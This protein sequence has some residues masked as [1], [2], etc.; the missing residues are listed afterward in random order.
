VL[1]D[2]KLAR[3][4]P[5]IV[6]DWY[7]ALRPN[8]APDTVNRFVA[9]VSKLCGIARVSGWMVG[10]PVEGLEKSSP[11]RRIDVFTTDEIKAVAANLKAVAHKYPIGVALIRFMMIFPSRGIEVRTLRHAELDLDAGTWTIPGARYKTG[12]DKVFPLGPQQIAH[13]RSLP[14]WSDTYVF[15]SPTDPAQPMRYEYQRDVWQKVRPARK[16]GA[17]T[18]R[19]TLATGLLNKNVPLEIVSK[20]LGHSSTAVTQASYAHLA[21][22]TA[23]QYLDL[24]PDVLE[25]DKA[26]PELDEEGRMLQAFAM[27]RIAKE[28][29]AG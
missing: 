12:K 14:R 2:K 7:D 5:S 28:E 1:G 23:R 19:K 4:T 25:D 22:S 18:L 21:P 11:I 13:L 10:N 29:R 17:H 24:I 27:A 16:L 15:P 3:L 9:Y 8:Y 20:L 26:V 6:R